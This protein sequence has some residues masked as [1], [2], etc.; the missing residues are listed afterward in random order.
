MRVTVLAAVLLAF[1]ITAQAQYSGGLNS[2]DRQMEDDHYS[3]RMMAGEEQKE[4]ASDE[5]LEFRSDYEGE[6]GIDEEGMDEDGM[7]E[8]AGSN[9]GS[10]GPSG[11]PDEYQ[12]YV[13]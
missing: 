2:V 12:E 8:D 11:L 6:D 9:S 13:Q 1:G 10:T 5:G 4:R 7:G 3:D